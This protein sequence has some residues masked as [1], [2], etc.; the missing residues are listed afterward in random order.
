MTEVAL[1]ASVGASVE[2]EQPITMAQQRTKT[3]MVGTY[4]RTGCR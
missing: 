3:K 2:A 1:D 4:L